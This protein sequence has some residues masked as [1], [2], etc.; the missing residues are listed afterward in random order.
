MSS[1]VQKLELMKVKRKTR[2][3]NNAWWVAKSKQ[4]KAIS[5][6]MI[7]TSI[8]SLIFHRL[9]DKKISRLSMILGQAFIQSLILLHRQETGSVTINTTQL[10]SMM[11]KKEAWMSN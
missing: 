4:Y 1:K 11:R 3:K 7:E 9:R 10:M 6:L 2:R 5:L 8:Q